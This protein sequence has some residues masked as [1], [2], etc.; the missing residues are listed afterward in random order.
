LWIKTAAPFERVRDAILKMH[1]Y[2]LPECA[3]I[4]IEDGSPA[5]LKWLDDSS[6]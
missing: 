5:Y 4:T 2:E 6:K 1:S 3:S